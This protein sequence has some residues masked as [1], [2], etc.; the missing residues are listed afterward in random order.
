[1]YVSHVPEIFTSV[2]SPSGK[3]QRVDSS[4]TH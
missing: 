3:S 1:V 2:P 4:T